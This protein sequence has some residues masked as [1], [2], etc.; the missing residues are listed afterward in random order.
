MDELIRDVRSTER[1]AGVDRIYVPGE[2][3][4]EKR[5]ENLEAGIPVAEGVIAELE[6]FGRGFALGSLV[7]EGSIKG[8]SQA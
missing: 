1:A 2:I 8:T 3:E 6:A 5:L 7:Q 4:H